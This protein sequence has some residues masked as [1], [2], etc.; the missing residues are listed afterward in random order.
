VQVVDDDVSEDGDAFLVLELLD[1]LG[2]DKLVTRAGGRLPLDATCAIAAQVLDVLAAAHTKGIVHRDI[3]PANLFV[4]RDGGVKVLDFGIARVRESMGNSAHTTGGGMLLGTPAYMAPE[5]AL[6]SP[7]DVDARADLWAVGA[8]FFALASGTTVHEADSAQRLL[9]RLITQPARSLAA[10][11]PGVPKEIVDV[12]DAALHSDRDRR[13][14]SARAMQ[15]A[16]EEAS[17]LAFGAPPSRA[18]IEPL[19]ASVW[20]A[21]ASGPAP[22]APAPSASPS[23]DEGSVRPP[24]AAFGTT[25]PEAAQLGESAT[26][27]PVSRDGQAHSAPRR[28]RLGIAAVVLA[29]AALATAVVAALGR[30]GADRRASGLSTEPPDRPASARPNPAPSVPEQAAA[31]R[32][33]PSAPIPGGLAPAAIP[34]AHA[35]AGILSA[36]PALPEPVSPR[37]TPA[38]HD[39]AAPMHASSA[40]AAPEGAAAAPP[41]E[42]QDAAP[43]CNPPFYYDSAWNRVFRKECLGK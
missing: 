5:Q 40:S 1:G 27:R 32:S 21:P 37:P 35:S 17:R 31:S 11:A 15:T 4:L 18:A 42:A 41:S 8:T 36:A 39:G 25:Q 19:I 33:E 10:A 24:S 26:S 3:K 7:G 14:A 20:T 22:T 12:I 43:S 28:R 2:C 34:P 9:V 29:L 38:R 6:G 23:S 13:W 30:E 16:L